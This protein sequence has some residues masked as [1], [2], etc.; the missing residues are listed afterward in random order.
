MSK[1]D[2]IFNKAFSGKKVFLHEDCLGK[3]FESESDNNSIA[4]AVNGLSTPEVENG[5]ENKEEIDALLN[6]EDDLSGTE[7]SPW[8]RKVRESLMKLRGMVDGGE[9]MDAVQLI[10]E[11][12][13]C[14]KRLQMDLLTKFRSKKGEISYERDS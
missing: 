6:L 1:E 8:Q 3:V 11:T 13:G 14:V 4:V 9:K 10:Q 5:E 7:D 2:S 12:I